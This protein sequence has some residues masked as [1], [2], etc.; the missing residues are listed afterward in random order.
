MDMASDMGE[1]DMSKM[2][3]S[4][5]TEKIRPSLQW[6]R[7]EKSNRKISRNRLFGRNLGEEEER[8]RKE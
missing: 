3:I 5:S 2:R 8:G 7:P 4:G 1:E 6:S